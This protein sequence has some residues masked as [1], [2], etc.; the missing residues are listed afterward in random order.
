MAVTRYHLVG[1][2]LRIEYGLLQKQSKRVR[3]NRVQS[4][5]IL[6]PLAARVF[7]LA[8]VKVTTAGTERAAVRLRY[9]SR[10]V[11]QVLRAD[12]LGRSTWG[13]EGDR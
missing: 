4:V 10:P 2:E 5:D 1:G 3:L 11:A 7:G 12:L 8:E 6:E 13:V 9:V